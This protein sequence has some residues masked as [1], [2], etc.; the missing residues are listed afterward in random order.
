MD[1]ERVLT[2][3]DELDSYRREL[4]EILP[5]SYEDYASSTETKRA[6]ERLIHV[7][8]ETLIDT[9][10]LIVKELKLGLPGEEDDI[11]LK[12]EKRNIITAGMLTKLKRMKGFRNILVHRYSEIDDELVFGFL[13]RNLSD[14]EI[15]KKQILAYL[16][17]S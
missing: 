15:Y 5:E 7:M 9:S 4:D 11:F 16:K 14:F 2:K 17:R 13:K 10:A 8:I 3:I 1:K 6:C 12:L